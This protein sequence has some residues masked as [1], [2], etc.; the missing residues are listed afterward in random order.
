MIRAIR[1][2]LHDLLCPVCRRNRRQDAKLKCAVCGSDKTRF[3]NGLVNPPRAYCFA[4][5][6]DLFPHGL[7]VS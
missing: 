3:V 2:Y 5:G 7:E 6:R 4:C 1:S